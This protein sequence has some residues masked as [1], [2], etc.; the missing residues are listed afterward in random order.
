MT[1]TGRE[2]SRARIEEIA[3]REEAAYRQR[4]PRS[5][6]LFERARQSLPLGVASSFQAYDPYPLFMTDA[7]GSRI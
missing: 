7:R 4:T 6:E 1:V 5:A 3:T 2:V